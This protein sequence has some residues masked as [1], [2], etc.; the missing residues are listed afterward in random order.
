MI[1]FKFGANG[2]III[3]YKFGANGNIIIL[4]IFV[5]YSNLVQMGILL[6][7]IY[8]W[9]IQIWCKWEYYYLVYICGI[10]KFGANGNIIILYIF[11][12]YSNLVQMGILLSCIYL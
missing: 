8:L 5:E 9:N 11:V 6:S 2:N 4:Y 12:E 1:I 3:L 7:C 10:F